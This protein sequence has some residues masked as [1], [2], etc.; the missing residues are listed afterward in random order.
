MPTWV[1]EGSF[2]AL[3]KTPEETSLIAN[4]DCVPKNVRCESDWK[5][6]RVVGTLDFS[7][8]G[9]IAGLTTCLANAG[10]SVFVQS[11]FDTDYL[12]VREDQLQ[13]AIESLTASGHSIEFVDQRDPE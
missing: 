13:L 12:M 6:M 5:L 10:V 8:T 7:L 9:V 2:Y 4:V 11:T 1:D 3:V